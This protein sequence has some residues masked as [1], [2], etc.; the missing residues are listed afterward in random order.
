MNTAEPLG[1]VARLW[2]SSPSTELRREAE[3]R[4]ANRFWAVEQIR[5]TGARYPPALNKG[6]PAGTQPTAKFEQ[7]RSPKRREIIIGEGDGERK[8]TFTSSLVL[9]QTP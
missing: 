6:H 2:L 9:G 7:E 8:V 3:I 5:S 1:R 4:E